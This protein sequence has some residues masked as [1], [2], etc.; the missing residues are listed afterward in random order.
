[1]FPHDPRSYQLEIL[2]LAK[3]QNIIACLQTGRFRSRVAWLNHLV[4][5]HSSA[6]CSLKPLR[7]RYVAWKSVDLTQNLQIYKDNPNRKWTVFLVPVVPLVTQ[8][9]HV[10][11]CMNFIDTRKGTPGSNSS[12]SWPI[13]WINLRNRL[14]ENARLAGRKREKSNLHHDT[15]TF[16]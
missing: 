15:S 12:G 13:F 8:Q 10:C 14:V 11:P 1:M 2:E 16:P 6:L 9:A 5:R 3:K 4:E 7:K